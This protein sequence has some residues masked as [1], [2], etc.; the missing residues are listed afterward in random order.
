M[1]PKLN[2]GSPKI[3]LE[4]LVR[5]LTVSNGQC[6][7]PLRSRP[8]KTLACRQ[9][10]P[11]LRRTWAGTYGLGGRLFLHT[12][13]IARVGSYDLSI[14]WL[15]YWLVVALS[16]YF[17]VSRFII[18]RS[19]IHSNSGRTTDNPQAGR[20]LRPLGFHT[21]QHFDVSRSRAHTGLRATLF[22]RAHGC[23]PQEALS[24]MKLVS[25]VQLSSRER[26]RSWITEESTSPHRN[27]AHEGPVSENLR[28]DGCN[29]RV[30]LTVEFLGFRV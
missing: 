5:K 26:K 12:S 13:G 27:W 30:P 11:P 18:Y 21:P 22:G 29:F 25:S 28:R 16:R 23:H 3:A 1:P 17:R 7:H 24:H 10:R 20:T 8:N 15:C 6:G 4:R 9:S 19:F 2:G 14:S